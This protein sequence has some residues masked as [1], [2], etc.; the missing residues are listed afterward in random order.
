MT[1]IQHGCDLLGRPYQDPQNCIFYDDVS[2]F[3]YPKMNYYELLIISM[4]LVNMYQ[5]AQGIDISKL[6]ID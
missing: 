4:Y 3:L 5:L 1:E 6:L 2:I